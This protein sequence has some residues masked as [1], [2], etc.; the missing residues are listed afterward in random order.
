MKTD[1]ADSAD[2]ER[3]LTNPPA[4]H[5]IVLVSSAPIKRTNAMEK[6]EPQEQTG[7]LCPYR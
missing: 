3:D 1:E 5:I 2:A 6:G 4:F 7:D